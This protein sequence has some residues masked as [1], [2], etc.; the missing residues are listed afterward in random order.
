[1]IEEAYFELLP[2]LHQAQRQLELCDLLGQGY[3]T[4]PGQYSAGWF[5]D[6]RVQAPLQQFQTRLVEI[7]GAIALRN[8][9]RP[10]PYPYLQPSK[11][12]QSI[13]I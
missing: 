12:P 4:V 7:E 13:N 10:Y 9:T 2:P 3:H 6:D 5:T 11:I 1:V 8:K